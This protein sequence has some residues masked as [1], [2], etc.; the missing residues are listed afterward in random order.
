MKK[1]FYLFFAM[2]A[3]I[4]GVTFVGCKTQQ[5]VTKKTAEPTTADKVQQMK[6]EAAFIKAQQELED[7]KAAAARAEEQRKANEAIAAEN[8]K[9][10][11][12]R[13]AATTEQ[14]CQI[15]DD[16]EWYTATGERRIKQSSINTAA[17]ALLRSTQQQL[18]QKLKSKYRGVVRD[19]FDQM[20]MDE[21]SYAVSH[22]ESAGDRIID[23][24]INETYEVCRRNTEVDGQGFVT[25]YMA[26]KIS[27]KGVV[28]DIVNEISKD[29]QMEVRFNE[30]QFR[31]S[32]FKVFEQDQRK[33]YEEYES[34]RSKE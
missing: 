15:Y 3:I 22:I 24:K 32:A 9:K 29:K 20:D 1:H 27:K 18:M 6:D 10:Q 21:G 17:T 13:L 2:T 19:Y 25:L 8:A 11:A 33:S 14:P 28:D 31:E 12:E 5:Q 34:N 23:Q 4:A 16:A 30:K 26:I 7:A